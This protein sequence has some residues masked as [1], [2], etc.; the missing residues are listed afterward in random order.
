MSVD[1]SK[2]IARSTNQPDRTVIVEDV[3]RFYAGQINRVNNLPGNAYHPQK[4]INYANYRDTA[5]MLPSGELIWVGCSI[6]PELKELHR[7]A[8]NLIGSWRLDIAVGSDRRLVAGRAGDP[9]H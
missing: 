2:E 6:A 3:G 4:M 8:L 9:A 7:T 1:G 5:D